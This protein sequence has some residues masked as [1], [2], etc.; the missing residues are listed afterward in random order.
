ML[1]K[2]DVIQLLSHA[3]VFV[4]PSVYEPMGIVNLEAMACEAAVVATAVGGIAEVV[5]D[6][7]TGLLVPFEARRRTARG[8]PRRPRRASPPTSP[9][10]VNELLADPARADAM[11]AA[12][13]RRAV[14][15]FSWPAIAA[16]TVAVYERAIPRLTAGSARARH[17]SSSSGRGR[18]SRLGRAWRIDVGRCFRPT[19]GTDA[20]VQTY[21]GILSELLERDPEVQI[22]EDGARRRPRRRRT[23]GA[24]RGPGRPRQVDAAR[25][26]ARPCRASAASRCS[27]PAGASSSASSRS[28]SRASCSRRAC[29]RRAPPSAG[30]C[31]RAARAW[32][33]SCSASIRPRAP[34]GRTRARRTR[35]CTACTGWPRTSPSA[36]RSLLV[37][38]DAH[39]AD[40]LSLRLRR[41]PRRAR[42]PT[43]RSRSSSPIG[44]GLRA[45]DGPLLAQLAAEPA[46]RVL[47]LA[48]LSEAA[49]RRLVEARAPGAEP[50]FVAACHHATG[51]NP[52]LLTELLTALAQEGV[53]P[54]RRVS[55][56]CARSVPRRCRAPSR[57]RCGPS[58]PEA[59]AVARAL[60]VLGDGAP[61]ARLAALSGIGPDAAR[62]AVDALR[63]AALL[64][65][66]GRG[67]VRAPDR[68]AGDLRGDGRDRAR[69]GAP[70][71]RSRS[72]TRPARPSSA[73]PPT[74]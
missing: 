59:T 33:P 9:P 50:A 2:P 23:A 63:A 65:P 52:F 1:P 21:G 37:V 10:R 42:S 69:G 72:C 11:G 8:E 41:V 70:A 40:E 5:E 3:T 4:C 51:G 17:A 46:A 22:I 34:R 64:A 30:G 27:P 19:T 15:R 26:R 73:S 74:R 28:A 44:P 62:A 6:G 56:A 13:R 39:W 29:A 20:R 66:A 57:W 25:G 68:R 16:E 60:A 55:P 67:R 14:E 58:P 47:R 24:R 45:V 61:V 38:D 53:A 35:S 18:R 54:T 31:C 12:G 36:R 7:V 49:A 32:P 48:P 43:C 71:R